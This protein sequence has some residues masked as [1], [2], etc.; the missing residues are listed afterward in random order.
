M[1]KILP[2]FL[3][4]LLL[5]SGCGVAGNSGTEQ[6][7]PEEQD[8]ANRHPMVGTKME[9]FTVETADGGTFTL[10]EALAE[11]DM[12]FINLWATWCGSCCYEFPMIQETYLA[13]QDRVD[14]IALSTEPRDTL[15][16]IADFAQSEGLTFELARD[17]E[18][19]FDSFGLE[20]IPSCI[21]VDRFGTVCF[22]GSVKP[23]TEAFMRLFD[24]FVG[25]NYE[26]SLLLADVPPQ[27]PDAVAASADELTEAL[28]AEVTGTGG[29]FVWPMQVTEKD[30]RRVAVSTN[31]G[32]SDSEAAVTLLVK[33]KAGDAVAVTFKTSVE[34]SADVF[35]IRANGEQI[36][37]F[38]GEHDWMTY[39][40]TVEEK[41]S[42]ELELAF[43]KDSYANWGE[44]TVWIDS[45]QVLSGRKAEKALAENPVYPVGDEITAV[46]T[47]CNAKR[48]GFND[49]EG[50]L[51]Y[52]FE[53]PAY[54]LVDSDSVKLSATLTADVDPEGAFFSNMFSD[55]YYGLG[56][57]MTAEGYEVVCSVS[58]VPEIVPFTAMVLGL[59]PGGAEMR[60]VLLFRNEESIERFILDFGLPGGWSFAKDQSGVNGDS[61]GE[62]TYT[63]RCVDQNGDG[64]EGVTVQICDDSSCRVAETDSNGLHVFASAPCAWEIYVLLPPEG[65]TAD[66][67]EVL[68]TGL[69]GGEVVLTLTKN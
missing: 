36:K 43:N 65:Y 37:L 61:D 69:S 27:K 7:P 9:D 48:I 68:R 42:L 44:D 60:T 11:K 13:Y 24:A 55:G 5:L 23:E 40:W 39:A 14:V 16:V 26:S 38:S 67:D 17:T 2:V 19:F 63:V 64:V 52:A 46:P 20:A 34:P 41:G 21:V 32:V 59:D 12:V 10:S 45:V 54:Y 4:L 66:P 25:E 8:D 33:A 30:G 51:T 15:E 28:G 47:E 49:P 29:G 6:T 31:T 56:S 53:D 3:L 18:G 35:S 1:K 58:S 22:V 57:C 50:I 62:V